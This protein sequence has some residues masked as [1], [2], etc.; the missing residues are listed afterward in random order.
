M[1]FAALLHQIH[2]GIVDQPSAGPRL[3]DIAVFRSMNERLELQ[4]LT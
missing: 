1:P 3:D 2:P 4:D